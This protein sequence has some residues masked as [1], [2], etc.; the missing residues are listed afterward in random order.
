MPF[1]PSTV[2]AL[3]VATSFGAGLNV[4]ATLLTLGVLAHWVALPPGLETLANPWIIG[5]SGALFA[6]EFVADKLPGLDLV[7]GGLHTFVRIPI[8]GLLAYRAASQLT[9]GMQLLTAGMGAVIALTTHGAKTAVRVAVAPNLKPV[10]YFAL[11]YG[12]DMAAV[13]IAWLATQHPWVAASIVIPL[14]LMAVLMMRWAVK[15]LRGI[16]R[17]P[18]AAPAL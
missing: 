16:C 13:G 1:S 9:P 2:A 15:T 18:S 11:S 4:Y 10:L 8:A 6:A 3:V 5:V 17:R 7:W 14:L 12:E